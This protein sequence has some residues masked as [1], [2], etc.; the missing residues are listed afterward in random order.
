MRLYARFWDSLDKGDQMPVSRTLLVVFISL[1][2]FP[3]VVNDAMG[4]LFDFEDAEYPGG[5]EIIE[6]YMEDVYGSDI[7]VTHAVVGD[8]LLPGLL[9]PDHYIQVG[10]AFGQYEMSISFHEVQIVAVEF[11]WAVECNNFYAYADGE[12]FFSYEGCP[13]WTQGTA[14]PFLFDE[15]IETLTFSNSGLWEIEVDN[16]NVTPVPEPAVVCLVGLAGLLLLRTRRS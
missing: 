15:P 7:T 5:P 14:G 11:D 12:L 3:A 10:P 2:I 9:G 6:A 8:G 4:V 1:L 13:S 16:L